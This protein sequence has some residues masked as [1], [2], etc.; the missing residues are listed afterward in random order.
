MPKAIIVLTD[1]QLL[2]VLNRNLRIPGEVHSCYSSG[3][4][5][6]YHSILVDMHPIVDYG[7][8]FTFLCFMNVVFGHTYDIARVE[9][10]E[11][12]AVLENLL[13]AAS[14]FQIFSSDWVND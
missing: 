3:T 4:I 7:A 5:E 10:P 6:D 8:A 11:D 13:A 2:D 1:Q 12:Y 14:H 9:D